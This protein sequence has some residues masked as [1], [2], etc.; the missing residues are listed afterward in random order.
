[1]HISIARELFRLGWPV[2]VAQL[3]VMA[4]AVVDTLFAGRYG[5]HDL[6]AV[7]IG[8][9]VYGAVA[10]TLAGVLFGLLPIVAQLEGAG[11]RS[12]VGEQVRQAA[13]LAAA[14]TLVS[15]ALLLAPD[16]LLALAKL[17]PEVERKARTYLAVMALAAPAAV[18][19]R[20]FHGFSTAV[21]QPRVIT[22]LQA[23]G[24]AD[25]R[26]RGRAMGGR[27]CRRLC[28][29]P[30]PCRRRRA[31]NAH[32]DGGERLLAGGGREPR[33]GRGRGDA[34][35]PLRQS[36]ADARRPLSAERRQA[37]RCPQ[38]CRVRRARFAHVPPRERH[39]RRRRSA[40]T[41]QTQCAG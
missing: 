38:A 23:R 6:A 17:T 35:L 40:P 9:S 13:W 37:R 18:L 12:E 36:R 25:A 16:P 19:F 7:G 20:V 41:A 1:L 14:I 31:C 33:G 32:A 11:R 21:S 29:R 15:V 2:L 30:R 28:P 3:A 26:L 5:T 27:T 39:R 24:G 34:L 4:N 10:V 8:A 22:R